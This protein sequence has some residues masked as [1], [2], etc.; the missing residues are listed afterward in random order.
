MADLT[1]LPIPLNDGHWVSAKVNRVIQI[2]QDYDSS[3]TVM[4]I[5]PEKRDNDDEAFL[6][7]EMTP[8]GPKPVFAVKSEE[9]M[10]E[11]LLEQIYRYDTHK[12]GDVLSEIDARNKARRDMV[13][14]K[15][16]EEMQAAHELAQSILKSPKVRYRHNGVVYE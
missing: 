11:R 6:V 4:W 8:Q 7:V 1:D 9:Y 5:P 13:R 3:L 12:H 2:L 14:A 15:H 10:D 16:E